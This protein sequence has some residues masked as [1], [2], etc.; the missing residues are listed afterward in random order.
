MIVPNL[1]LLNDNNLDLP[2][3]PLSPTTTDE[4]GLGFDNMKTP[5]DL[6]TPDILNDS[7]FNGELDWGSESSTVTPVEPIP[8]YTARE[9]FEDERHWRSVNIGGRWY[10]IDMKVIEPYKK[11]LSHGGGCDLVIDM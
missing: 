8:E 4:I 10:K 1:D 7:M 6:A 5:D 9:E 2:V 3:S 11:V